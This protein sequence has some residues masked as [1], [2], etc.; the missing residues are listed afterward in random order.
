MTAGREVAE[1]YGALGLTLRSHPVAFL[2]RDLAARRIVPCAEAGLARDGRRLAT[3]GL[4]LVRQRPGSANGVLFMTIEDE[5]GFANI[6]V[7]PDLFERQRHVILSAGMLAVT[8][9]V[10]REGEIVH[11]IA[12][13]LT[14]L[15]ELLRGLGE[16]DGCPSLGPDPRETP[17]RKSRDIPVPDTRPAPEIPEIKVPTRDFR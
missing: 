8:G 14:D 3:A 1:D 17:A 4:V 9:R 16:R 6:V 15:S 13:A 2:R 12:R 10:Q 5:T 7:R 11:V